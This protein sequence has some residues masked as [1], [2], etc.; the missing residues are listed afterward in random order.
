MAEYRE[1]EIAES[2]QWAKDREMLCS[3]AGIDAD[4]FR[5]R[6]AALAAKCPQSG[7]QGAAVAVIA[8]SDTAQGLCN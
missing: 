5:E 2:G 1:G 3:L 7:V 8:P 4:A 6:C